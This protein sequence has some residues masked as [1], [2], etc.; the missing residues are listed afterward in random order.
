MRLRHSEDETIDTMR[1]L[2][3]DQTK[4][5]AEVTASMAE[6]LG[7]HGRVVTR[8]YDLLKSVD[9]WMPSHI[10]VDLVM[11]GVDGVEVM[12]LLARRR[13]KARIIICS[14]M[15][16][17]ILNAAIR[18]A[19]ASGL[20]VAGVLNKPFTV[21]ELKTL[22]DAPPVPTRPGRLPASRTTESA[23]MP[24]VTETA[25]RRALQTD[26]MFPVFMPKVDCTTGELSGIE[27]FARWR[28]PQAGVLAAEQF[29]SLAERV[30]LIDELTES[31]AQ[32]ALNWLGTAFPA[33]SL[34]LT[35][36]L[37]A[38]SLDS[39]RLIETLARH[40]EHHGLDPRRIT[41]QLSEAAAMR[42]TVD[43]LE[44]LTRLRM[45]GFQLSIGNFGADQSSLMQLIRMP[46]SELKIA[47]GI[48][49]TTG[50]TREG[51]IV[52]KCIVDLGANLGL[53]VTASGIESGEDLRYF[54]EIGAHSAMGF[55]FG[56]PMEF[57]AMRG[58]IIHWHSGLD[59][60]WEG[61]LD[62]AALPTIGRAHSAASSHQARHR[63]GRN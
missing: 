27:A 33:S 31:I 4:A 23:A 5:V 2:V 46:V 50:A 56:H 1:L 36:K 63:P 49:G 44:L 12:N 41:L 25:L 38:A 29:I 30:A 51:R 54:R 19:T 39:F 28:H 57:E 42:E 40:C 6:A 16:G 61:F 43:T 59:H 14:G 13:C 18:A 37:S 24:A 52:A 55:L 26:E 15:D 10:A 9:E 17:T 45:R 32:Q 47:P 60:R 48:S 58:W 34:G 21:R 62:E 8:V 35:L 7:G 22:L 3:M 11:P 53:R 20:D